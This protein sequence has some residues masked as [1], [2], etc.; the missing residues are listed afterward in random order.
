MA[1]P[2]EFVRVLLGSSAVTSHHTTPILKMA[3]FADLP[4]YENLHP[5]L[6]RQIKRYLKNK[7]N[8]ETGA[9]GNW[10]AFIEAVNQ[11]YFEFDEDQALLERS[12]NLSSEELLAA[13]TRLQSLLKT[14]EAQVERRT[15]DL[16]EANAILG[17]TIQELQ[18]TQLQLIQTEKMSSL[19]QMVAGIAHEIN[20]PISFIRGNL[21]P[22]REYFQALKSL[23]EAYRREYP[24]PSRKILEK[25]KTADLEFLLEDLPKLMTSMEVGTQRVRDIVVSLRNFSRM[26]EATVKYADIHEGI[27][28]TLLILS[29]RIKYGVEIVR[30]YGSLP[31]VMCSPAQLNQAFTNIIANALDA[32]F[33]AASEPKQLMIKTR[34]IA[35]KKV[36]IS[37]RDT[38]PGIPTAI[39]PQIF[40][41]FFTTKPVGKGTG[42]GL[43]V[44][45]TI[46]QHHQGSIE[47]NSEA[48]S[49]AEFMITLPQMA[50]PEPN[51]VSSLALAS[52]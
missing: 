20:N 49:G 40:D 27:E 14:M 33:D 32:M 28:S 1:R 46:L 29:H 25:H 8:G 41:P 50:A 37:I 30:D 43:S 36:Q 34:A 9:C 12:L 52:Q 39:K 24:Q 38:G 45:F 4:E 42:L 51:P 7:G 23:L 6:G 47:V 5:L 16:A 31:P 11:A 21:A 48:G 2:S 44:C 19:G 35:G 26:D 22:L 10:P 3:H 18:E 13:N 15:H 17:K